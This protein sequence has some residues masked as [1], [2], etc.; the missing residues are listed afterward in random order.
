MLKLFSPKVLQWLTIF[1]SL[2]YVWVGTIGQNGWV[3]CFESDG[4]V[5]LEQTIGDVSPLCC[6][7]NDKAYEATTKQ[8]TLQSAC[9]NCTDVPLGHLLAS[10]VEHHVVK[11]VHFPD[12]QTL[13]FIAVNTVTP[14][15]YLAI[16]TTQT[17]A[18]PPPLWPKPHLGILKTVRLLI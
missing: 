5:V 2:I 18:N 3:L 9:K 15:G 17:L 4:H 10:Q 13:A 7:K 16:I 8:P 14:V 12:I 6:D 1:I 11:A